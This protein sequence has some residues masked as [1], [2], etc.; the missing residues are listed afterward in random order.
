VW[1]RIRE[2]DLALGAP[3]C[4]SVIPVKGTVEKPRRETFFVGRVPSDAKRNEKPDNSLSAFSPDLRSRS[5]ADLQGFSTLP[6]TGIHP[7]DT[8]S[9]ETLVIKA[10]FVGANPNPV[11]RGGDLMEYKCNYFLGNDPS[12]W[13]TDV[14]NYKA[15]VFEDI[16]AG[17]DL[18]YYGNGD[19]K[20][21]YDFLVSPGADV[22][23]IM[24]QYDGAKSVSVAAP[25]PPQ[26]G[27]ANCSGG[28]VP[29]D[30]DDIVYLINYIF[31]SGP[32]PCADCP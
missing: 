14:P 11:M 3:P 23:Q 27:D 16:Y 26:A 24:V 8:D 30:I 25:C 17:I 1:T 10:T 18:K 13:H 2:R 29:L 20:M 28:D 12:K 19:G 31:A 7:S 9:I 32:A 5:E 6:K 22:S 4:E 15:V 21:E